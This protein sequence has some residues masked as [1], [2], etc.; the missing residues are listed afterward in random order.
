MSCEKRI[1]A[2]ANSDYAK[3]TGTTPPDQRKNTT[4][5]VITPRQ[6]STKE[7]WLAE[8][9]ADQLWLDVRAY[10]ADDLEQW[11]EES[12][13]IALS[14]GEELGIVGSGIESL[15]RTWTAWSSQSDPKIS[16]EALFSAREPIREKLLAE[17]H[18][19]I[20]GSRAPISLRADSIS[21]AVAFACATILQDAG[22]YDNAAVITHLDGWRYIEKNTELKIAIAANPEIAARAIQ[23]NGLAVIAP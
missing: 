19:A 14:F 7:R 17:V 9:R 13:A 12:P 21:E 15:T 3:R 2:K 23:R 22:L 18:A 10:D 8:K 6:W 11:L 1:A 16:S 4:L 20:A 5:I